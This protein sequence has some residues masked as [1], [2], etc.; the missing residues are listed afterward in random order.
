MSYSEPT[1]RDLAEKALQVK[2]QHAGQ[3]SPRLIS[4]NEACRLT[5]LSRTAI[6]RWRAIGRFPVAVPLGD[7][8]VAFLRSEVDAWIR[9]R[10]A[11][12]AVRAS[13]AA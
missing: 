7:K 8:R 5:S 3:E 1:Q 13:E 4:L 9:E 6:N 12:R 11:E 10:I 2:Q